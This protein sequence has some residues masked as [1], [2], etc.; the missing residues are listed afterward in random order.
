MV[1]PTRGLNR[2]IERREI[3][4]TKRNW[5]EIKDVWTFDIFGSIEDKSLSASSLGILSGGI[6]EL[7]PV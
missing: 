2:S 5:N 7:S 6:N 4:G 1:P 3:S